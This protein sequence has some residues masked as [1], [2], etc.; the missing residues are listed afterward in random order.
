MHIIQILTMTVFN[1]GL[2]KFFKIQ[3]LGMRKRNELAP[4]VEDRA[5]FRSLPSPSWGSSRL[6]GD[7]ITWEYLE[8]RGFLSCL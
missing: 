6:S 7:A 5:W 3:Q 4:R 8:S 1:N 2:L